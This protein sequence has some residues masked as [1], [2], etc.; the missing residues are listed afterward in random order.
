ML[1]YIKE[2][3]LLKNYLNPIIKFIL[4][5]FILSLA[6]MAEAFRV[7]IAPVNP[8]QTPY[9]I[10]INKEATFVTKAYFGEKKGSENDPELPIEKLF[11]QFD[12]TQLEKVSSKN[13]AITLKAIRE[14]RVKLTATG[15]V[16][17]YPFTA[18]IEIIIEK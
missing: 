16:E 10:K 6:A 17:S 9:S 8:G 12:Y 2:G 15:I 18:S 1:Q 7:E 14:G 13:G 4:I 11:W 3:K 5:I